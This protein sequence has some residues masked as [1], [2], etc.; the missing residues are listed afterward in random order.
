MTEE[1]DRRAV[2]GVALAAGA[3]LSLSQAAHA[4]AQAPAASEPAPRPLPFGPRDVTGLSE[5]LLVSHR[6]NNYSGAVSRFGAIS[7]QLRDLDFASAPGFVVNGL[8]REQLIALNSMILHEVYFDGFAGDAR[9]PGARLGARIETDFGS[10]SRWRDEFSAMGKALGGGSGWVLLTWSPRLGRLINT[11]AA[12]HAMSAADGRV[13]AA[14]DM[15]E[16]AYA[17]DYGARAGAYVDAYMA[18]LRWGAADAAFA[19]N[20][21]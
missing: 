5:R 18:A 21:G 1:L 4:Q 20:G 12:D 14:L 10:F 8:K 2:F 17:M 19:R 11:W 3:M 6:D 15:Y 16:H 7:A 13:L 9:A